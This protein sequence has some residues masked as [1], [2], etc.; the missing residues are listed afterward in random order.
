[1]ADDIVHSVCLISRC[2]LIRFPAIILR[3]IDKLKQGITQIANHNYDE[4]LDFGNNKEFHAVATSFNDMACKLS[5]YRRSSLDRLMTEKK[6]RSHRKQP[7]RTDHRIGSG[8]QY[9]FYERR[10]IFDFKP[11]KRQYHRA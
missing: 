5:E 11:E 10:G 3:P 2:F 7:A 1:M 9:P 4:R 6:N 8:A